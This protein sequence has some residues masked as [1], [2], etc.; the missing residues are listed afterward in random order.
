[1]PPMG[2]RRPDPAER[3]SLIK[4]LETEL[5][6]AAETAPNPGR[7]EVF[8]RL[9][10]SEYRNAVR[11]L[12]G[13]DMDVSGFL[14]SDDASFGFDNIAGVLKISQSR[15]GQYLTAARKISR[16]AVGTPLPAPA[17]YE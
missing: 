4:Y 9:N 1:M 5:D 16:P 7:T 13:L 10:R 6:A 14:P 11:D 12:L 3:S 8:H 2:Q 17:T 15:L